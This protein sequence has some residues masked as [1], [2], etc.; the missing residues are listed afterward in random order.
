MAVSRIPIVYSVIAGKSASWLQKL[1]EEYGPVVRVAPSELSY[2]D[3]RAWTDIYGS[4]HNRHGKIIRDMAF[5][6]CLDDENGVPSI[7]T[8]NEADHARIRRAYTLAFSKQALISQEPLLVGH[9]DLLNWK[10]RETEQKPTD[11]VD[12]FKFSLFDI[13]ADL[14]FG[15]PF[16]LF[17]DATYVP[18]V[19]RQRHWIIASIILG[20]LADFPWIRN[21]FMLT[22]PWL[23]KKRR[24]EYFKCLNDRI[25]QRLSKKVDRPD[26]V[27]LIFHNDKKGL[28]EADVRANAQ[29]MMIAGAETTTSLL[30]GLTA[31]LLNKPETLAKLKE[32]IR[33][34]FAK[35]SDI[36]IAATS[37]LR[38]LDA[39]VKETL[40]IYPPTPNALPRVVTQPGAEI[41]GQWVPAGTRVYS[42]AL[43]T[44]CSSANFYK[45]AL[46]LPERWYT[47]A[48]EVFKDDNKA[49]CRPF[50]VGTRDCLGQE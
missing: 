45:P 20:A 13:L 9:V 39:C 48:D 24:E 26:I 10:L 19:R 3:S 6:K 28:S 11:M 33:K 47:D 43:S 31:H 22:F 15:E 1:H 50:S 34:A 25:D 42:S 21:V 46:F 37:R 14:Q 7:A 30:S 29:L 4:H 32:E 16:R 38:L 18:W 35:S 36:T 41:A 8:A 27:Q 2:A 44:F 5:F 23:V 12:M 17:E 40:R 49:A